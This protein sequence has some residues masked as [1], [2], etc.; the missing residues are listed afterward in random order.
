[1][2]ALN[3]FLIQSSCLNCEQHSESV[4]CNQSKDTLQIFESHKITNIYPKGAILFME[5]QPSNGIY[6]LCKGRVKLSTCSRDGK[7][8]ILHI[9]ESGEVLGLSTAISE[10]THIATAEV[11]EPCQIN[12]M[13]TGDFL[14]FL[15]Q[16][17]EAS[18]SIV[19]QLS[20]NYQT[21]FHQICSLGLSNTVAERLARLFLGWC[22]KGSKK[23]DGI[24][25][26]ITYTHEDLAQMIG[27][28]RETV[29]RI[30]KDFR[31]Q[32][33]ISIK[34]SNLIIHDKERLK[35]AFNTQ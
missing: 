12:F 32:K 31:N 18:L 3:Q 5:G 16:N 19:K 15:A 20:R 33:L 30:L 23:A 29:S 17:A 34:D 8:I 4:F 27:T 2:K 13:R 26:K 28:S 11:L 21:A 9:A 7:V 14:Q 35:S 22:Q 10:S 1:M 6:I 24:H 25:V